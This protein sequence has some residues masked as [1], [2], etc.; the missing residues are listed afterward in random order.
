[1]NNHLLW[2]GRIPASFSR[3]KMLSSITR[4]LPC[5][6]FPVKSRF[7][8]SACFFYLPRTA[9]AII[10]AHIFNLT[11][12]RFCIKVFPDSR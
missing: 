12:G 6:G 11:A 3:R 1:M 4:F 2:F 8:V 7:A 10:A 5:A 9:K